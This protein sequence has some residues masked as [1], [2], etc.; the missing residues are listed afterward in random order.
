MCIRDRINGTTIIIRK[1]AVS[2]EE[3][4]SKTI[5]GKVSDEQ[6]NVLP[7]DVYK[8][9]IVHFS[10]PEYFTHKPADYP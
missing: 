5:T 3:K 9:Q 4:K 6:G 1:K 8:R 7:G 10:P 2:Q